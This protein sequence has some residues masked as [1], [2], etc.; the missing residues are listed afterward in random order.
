M[1]NIKYK[2]GNI[3][4]ELPTKEG[5]DSHKFVVMAR[6]EENDLELVLNS[7]ILPTEGS[8]PFA[9]ESNLL[10]AE[11]VDKNPGGR[12]VGG[13]KITYSEYDDTSIIAGESTGYGIVHSNV[14]EIFG[15]LLSEEYK[16]KE[17]DSGYI[18]KEKN[19]AW[20]KRHNIKL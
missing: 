10:H 11:I 16:L 18:E 14:R 20:I 7:E 19:E 9:R 13:G 17:F 6:E 4:G 3:V 2:I 15:K 1:T 8:G 12:C 5:M